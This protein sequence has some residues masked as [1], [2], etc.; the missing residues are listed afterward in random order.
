MSCSNSVTVTATVTVSQETEKRR[1]KNEQTSGSQRQLRPKRRA[2]DARPALARRR[3][4]SLAREDGTARGRDPQTATDRGRRN[5][6][7]KQE[8][9]VRAAT[10]LSRLWL[11][12][13]RTTHRPIMALE[14]GSPCADR[15]TSRGLSCE[16]WML[17]LEELELDAVLSELEIA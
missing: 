7:P 13:T 4:G 6:R 5:V 11:D 8:H 17:A 16:D 15:S 12:R 2:A 9:T 3:G 14:C 10:R 1:Q